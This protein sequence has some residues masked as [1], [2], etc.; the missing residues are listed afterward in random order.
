MGC[1]RG[2]PSRA[3]PC[4]WTRRGTAA[5]ELRDVSTFGPRS[6]RLITAL[7]LRIASFGR[8]RSNGPHGTQ[9]P[10]G[11]GH[12]RR[13]KCPSS[14]G[15]L[16]GRT[17]RTRRCTMVP[18]GPPVMTRQHHWPASV[19]RGALASRGDDPAGKTLRFSVLNPAPALA[20]KR[21]V[22]LRCSVG[23]RRS[24]EEIR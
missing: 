16:C 15:R 12:M 20:S 2:I 7:A 3:L 23:T 11:F 1:R 10:L 24:T 5:P 4:D 21:R 14:R 19:G 17:I 13:G 22:F 9:R 8:D 6:I 18:R